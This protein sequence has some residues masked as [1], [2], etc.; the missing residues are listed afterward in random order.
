MVEAGFTEG[1]HGERYDMIRYRTETLN[2]TEKYP[3]RVKIMAN[4]HQQYVSASKVKPWHE[5]SKTEG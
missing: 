1:R 2:L 4:Q 5:I 3:E